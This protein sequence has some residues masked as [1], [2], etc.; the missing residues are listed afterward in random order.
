MA[1]FGSTPNRNSFLL[2][3]IKHNRK[4]VPMGKAAEGRNENRHKVANFVGDFSPT[5]H[6]PIIGEKLREISKAAAKKK[7]DKK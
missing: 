4:I 6:T 1:D 2:K 7:R 3:P 5:K